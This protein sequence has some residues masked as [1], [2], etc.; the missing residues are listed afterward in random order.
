L[1]TKP[2]LF[3]HSRLY[4][5]GEKAALNCFY[6]RKSRDSLRPAYALTWGSAT[7][8]LF[9]TT[10]RWENMAAARTAHDIQNM[11]YTQNDAVL[12]FIGTAL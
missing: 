8:R 6:L 9:I 1:K 10:F 4:F 5:D 3:S 12:F 7:S 11:V 2:N